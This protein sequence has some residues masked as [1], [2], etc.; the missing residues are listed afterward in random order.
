MIRNNMNKIEPIAY[1]VL[2]KTSIKQDQKFG[3]VLAI[4]MI[5]GIIV[6]VI[7]AVQECEKNKTEN[8]SF[9]DYAKYYQ[10]KFKYLSLRRSWYT[11]MRIKKIIRQKLSIEDCKK[12][13]K[14]IHDAI[15]ETAI[16]LSEK[17]TSILMETV[18]ND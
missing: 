11:S 5:I 12:Y 6:N 16:N 7:R 14:E 17:E 13:K 10:S 4:L 1:K 15:L 9:E 2:N 8:F 3:S 18:N